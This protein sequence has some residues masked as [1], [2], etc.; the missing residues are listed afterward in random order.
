MK[1]AFDGAGIKPE[2]IQ[3]ILPAATGGTNSDEG[4]ARALGRLFGNNLHSSV[5]VGAPKILFGNLLGASGACD[6]AIACLAIE[7]GEAPITMGC[8]DPDACWSWSKDCGIAVS[9]K[10]ENVMINSI[11]RGG[12]NASLV[13][14]KI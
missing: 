3:Y 6:V 5:S 7:R 8:A 11:G 2:D 14:S 1:S 9:R 12:V 4:E 13:L 10:I